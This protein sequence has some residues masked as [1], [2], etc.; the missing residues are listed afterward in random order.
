MTGIP[1][2]ELSW[3]HLCSLDQREISSFNDPFSAIFHIASRR[4]TKDED[5]RCMNACCWWAQYSSALRAKTRF[6]LF[7]EISRR[8][9]HNLLKPEHFIVLVVCQTDLRFL[10]WI[11]IECIV[12]LDNFESTLVD[13]EVNVSLLEIRCNCFPNFCPGMS[14]LNCLPSTMPDS[15]AMLVCGNEE[16]R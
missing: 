3:P 4:E 10:V 9:I 7:V 14:P 1:D 6:P 5:K 2:V 11:G 8:E 15:A 12:E 16:E 13:I